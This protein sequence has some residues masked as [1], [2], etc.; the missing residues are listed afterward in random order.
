MPGPE[1]P[2]PGCAPHPDLLLGFPGPALIKHQLLMSLVINKPPAET[3]RRCNLATPVPGMRTGTLV[4]GVAA[5]PPAPTAGVSP[6][7]AT[8]PNP[9]SISSYRKGKRAVTP[10]PRAKKHRF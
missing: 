2:A 7:V 5:L 8:P 10:P 9:L 6:V 1:P 4:A 3:Q